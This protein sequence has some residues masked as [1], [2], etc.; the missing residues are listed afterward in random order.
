ME[1][2]TVKIF[3]MVMSGKLLIGLILLAGAILD[4]IIVP[5]S[6]DK[7]TVRQHK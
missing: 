1:Q 5:I 7:K 6:H 4:L 2:T 3:G